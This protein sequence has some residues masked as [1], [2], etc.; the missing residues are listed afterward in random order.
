MQF[1]Y[2]NRGMSFETMIDFTNNVYDRLG[3]ALVNK[4]P[5]PVKVTGRFRDGAIK[6]FF[7]KPSTVDYDGTLLGGK[8]IVF[9]A[10]TVKE[11]DRF[12]LKNMESHQVEYLAK[13]HRLGGVS[14]LL[15]ELRGAHTVYLIPYITLEY[16]WERRGT[17]RGTSSIFRDRLEISAYEVKS[18]R[19]PVD[20]LSEV[21]K[22]WKIVAA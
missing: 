13:C 8:S 6:G 4:R 5:T 14:F 11:S 2:A 12:E 17:G 21:Q 10:K 3:L 1:G 15:L 7:E 22:V 9:E 20:Y 18:G 16:F 19:V